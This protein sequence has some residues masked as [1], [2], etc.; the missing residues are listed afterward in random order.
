MATITLIFGFLWKA[1]NII[2]MIAL[3]IFF[4]AV[5]VQ[6]IAQWKKDFESR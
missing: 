4:L 6:A 2:A 3:I 1:L 5:N